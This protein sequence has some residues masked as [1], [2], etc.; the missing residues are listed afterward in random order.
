G[1]PNTAVT[2]KVNGI[3]GGNST[4]GTVTTAGWYVAPRN[5]PSPAGVTL[6]ATSQPFPASSGQAAI[7]V[8]KK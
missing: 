2:W 4:V 3:T 5:V 1:T 6:S 7:T 8:V